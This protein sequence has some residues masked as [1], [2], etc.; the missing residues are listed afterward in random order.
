MNKK[1]QIIKIIIVLL[2][3]FTLILGV[4]A[5]VSQRLDVEEFTI[6]I[7]ANGVEIKILHISDLHV[8]KNKINLN[9]L[10]N[11]IE[12]IQPDLIFLTGDTIDSQAREEDVDALQ[13][14]I[15]YIGQKTKCYATLGN[16]ELINSNLNKY[17]DMLSIAGVNLVIDDYKIITIE[18]K[19]I[20]IVG[21]NDSSLYSTQTVSGLNTIDKDVPVLLLAHRPEYWLEYIAS[22]TAPPDVTFAGHAHGGQFRFL[23]QGIFS[24]NQGWFPKYTSGLHDKNDKH[25][26]VSR[27]LGDSVF[28]LRIYNSYHLPVVKLI[29]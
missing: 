20:A 15:S 19:S 27:G 5:I 28:G 11:Y 14:F 12:D 24:P 1:S 6:P 18:N 8:P 23:G 9:E 16:H 3:F 10:M 4:G 7:N 25:M 13:P 29:I 17:K 22:E 21:I 26:I 2:I